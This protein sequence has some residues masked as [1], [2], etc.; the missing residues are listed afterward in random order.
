MTV[1][2]RCAY[3]TVYRLRTEEYPAVPPQESVRH[4]LQ[5]R[6]AGEG[7]KC[8]REPRTEGVCRRL[9]R[10]RC[11]MAI[12]GSARTHARLNRV[13]PRRCRL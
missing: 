4:R 11:V 8:I 7:E 13:E 2:L 6:A 3:N 10:R 1:S 9:R 12:E 5:A